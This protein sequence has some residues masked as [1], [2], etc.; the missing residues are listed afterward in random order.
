[1]QL[2]LDDYESAKSRSACR[3]S[4][5]ISRFFGDESSETDEDGEEWFPDSEYFYSNG[6]EKLTFQEEAIARRKE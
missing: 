5:C 4:R 6:F 2:A 1:M 3:S